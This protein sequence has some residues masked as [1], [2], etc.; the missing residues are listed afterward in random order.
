[1]WATVEQVENQTGKTVSEETLALASSIIDTFSGADEDL[2]E[3][4][5]SVVDRKHLR[6]ATGWQAVWIAAKP[7]LITERENASSVTSDTQNIQREDRADG[8]LAPLARREIV[9]LSWVG[10]RTSILRPVSASVLSRNFLNER[11]D[12][13]WFGGEGAIPS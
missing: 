12:P 9:A 8:L 6:K 2:P 4:A 7:G 3:D 11:S 1:M 5:I 13:A 10:S